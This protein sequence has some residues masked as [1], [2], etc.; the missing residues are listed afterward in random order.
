MGMRNSERANSRES[1]AAT[2]VSP[3]QFWLP[4]RNKRFSEKSDDDVS[5]IAV[6]F[7]QVLSSVDGMA[8]DRADFRGAGPYRSVFTIE[9]KEWTSPTLSVSR[10][11]AS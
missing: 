11:M 9:I 3:E 4:R 10:E 5:P 7:R 2:P 6:D 8:I 1:V